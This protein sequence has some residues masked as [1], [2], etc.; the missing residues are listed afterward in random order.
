MTG[1]GLERFVEAQRDCHATALRE[2]REGRKASH[3]MWYVFPQLARL[4]RSDRAI[5]FGLSGAA[6]ARAF[7]AH[8]LLGPRL[9]ACFAALLG[10]GTDD[11]TAVLGPVDA[12]KLRSCATLFRDAAPGTETARLADR[13]LARFYGGSTCALTRAAL[14]EDGGT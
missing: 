14:E 10:L 9:D 7:Q 13:V 12:L 8:P 11:A 3:W 6:E 1:A 4:G 2:L 5:R